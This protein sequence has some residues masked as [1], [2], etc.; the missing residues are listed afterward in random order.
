MREAGFYMAK[1]RQSKVKRQHHV[2][3]ELEPGLRFLSSLSSVAGVIPGI[4]SPKSGGQM[5]DCF[6]SF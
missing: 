2:V 1:Y 4:I 3:K 6:Q 5:G